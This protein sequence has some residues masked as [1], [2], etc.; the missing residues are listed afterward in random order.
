V[1]GTRSRAQRR[2]K[3]GKQIGVV[4][5]RCL[6]VA[7]CIH[8]CAPSWCF[9][10]FKGDRFVIACKGR[11]SIVPAKTQLS[12][13]HYSRTPSTLY[14]SWSIRAPVIGIETSLSKNNVR[15]ATSSG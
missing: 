5:K 7:W 1:V 15:R 13:M 14:C 11:I 9:L 8:D 4:P 10:M 2:P 6:I 3:S 12:P